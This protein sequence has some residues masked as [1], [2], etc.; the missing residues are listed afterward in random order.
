MNVSHL[1][2]T[3]GVYFFKKGAEILYIGKSVN[4][5]AR[6][7]SHLENAKI[8]RKEQLIIQNADSVDY[9][10]TDSEFKAILLEAQLIQKY[11]PN[12]NVIWRDDKSRLYIKITIAE[13]YPKILLVRRPAS[14]KTSACKYFGPFFSIR[15]ASNLIKEIRRIIPFC[16]QPKLSRRPCFYSKIDLCNPCPNSI[17]Y[18][19]S[20]IKYKKKLKKLYRKNIYSVIRILNGNVKGVLNELQRTIKKLS[21]KKAYEEAIRVRNK[22]FRFEELLYNRSFPDDAPDGYNQSAK[23]IQSL[24]NFLAGYFSTLTSLQRIEC[25]DISN[26]SLKNA[27]ASMVVLVDGL[28][29]RSE[30]RHFKIRSQK[31]RSDFAMLKEVLMRRFRNKWRRPDLVVV[32]G[33]KPQVRV[34]LSVLD[35]LQLAI[36][37]VGIAKNPDRLI[38]GQNNLP[39]IRFIS[40]SGSF[41]SIRLIRDESHRFARKYHLL[42]RDRNF[43]V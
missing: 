20:S 28:I 26:L 11:H 24:L 7:L 32:D 12:Y 5:K 42:L 38:I 1:P 29:Q 25:Y 3:T 16:T 2:N 34:V 27:T 6:V 9:R 35:S 8:D 40:S 39:T 43:L 21:R 10:V 33:G 14:V 17:E 37:V 15:T 13:D 41:N 23:N 36:P 31:H 30:Y 4:I 22:I 18:Q 19:V